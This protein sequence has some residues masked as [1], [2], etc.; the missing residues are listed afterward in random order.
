MEHFNLENGPKIKSGF[1]TPDTYFEGFTERLMEQ[2]PEQEVKVVPLYKKVPVWFSAVA[3]VLVLMIGFGLFFTTETA[4]AAQP[5]DAA[6]EN[7]LVYN[8]NVNAYDLGES[9]NEQDIAELEESLTINDEAIEDYL[10]SK[11]IDLNE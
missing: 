5:D 10:S 6:I 7:Y 9:L 4:V 3:A 1:T 11:N 8:A 2:L